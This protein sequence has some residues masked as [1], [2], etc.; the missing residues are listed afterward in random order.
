[1]QG[2]TKNELLDCSFLMFG[3]KEFQHGRRT[4]SSNE[5][6]LQTLHSLLLNFG[7]VKSSLDSLNSRLDSL[8][9]SER[10]SKM[11]FLL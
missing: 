9:R 3:Q 11:D 5:P 4:A 1:M 7:S 2:Q 6:I 8:V 10:A